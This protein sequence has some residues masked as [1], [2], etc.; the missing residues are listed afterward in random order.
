M[1]PSWLHCRFGSGGASGGGVGC[2]VVVLSC[3]SSGLGRVD[4]GARCDWVELCCVVECVSTGQVNMGLTAY[5]GVGE[6]D[7]SLGMRFRQRKDGRNDEDERE[8][9]HENED[10]DEHIDHDE[11][12]PGK[13]R[14]L[15]A[16]VLGKRVR[17][18][19]N[20]AD[21]ED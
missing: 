9:S 6:D 15:V 4:V 16:S 11:E 18:D 1:L 21:D 7:P 10:E 12:G 3:C 2:V 8:H 13:D 17:E 19:A 5:R 20:E 14:E